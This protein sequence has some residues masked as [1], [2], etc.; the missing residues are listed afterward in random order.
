M[1]SLAG[2]KRVAPNQVNIYNMATGDIM[3]TLCLSPIATDKLNKQY[4]E[5]VTDTVEKYLSYINKPNCTVSVWHSVLSSVGIVPAGGN[6]RKIVT[7]KATGTP[8]AN[9][10]LYNVDVLF[11]MALETNV[12]H[13]SEV[14][15]SAI[16]RLQKAQASKAIMAN[17]QQAVKKIMRR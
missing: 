8:L 17:R 7:I 14:Y 4:I 3:A 2:Y 5:S 13:A 6:G 16:E 15:L 11:N 10:N 9:I 12:A 1:G